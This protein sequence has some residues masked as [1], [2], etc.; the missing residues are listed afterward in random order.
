RRKTDEKTNGQLSMPGWRALFRLRMGL[1]IPQPGV[2]TAFV[3]PN[4]PTVSIPVTRDYPAARATTHQ[5]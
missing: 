4:G 3:I 5:V 2:R 1:M